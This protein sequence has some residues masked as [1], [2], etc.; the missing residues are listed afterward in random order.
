MILTIIYLLIILFFVILIGWNLFE[1]D[2][3]L[4]KALG[5]IVLIM[6]ILRLVLIK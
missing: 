4:E 2:S 6:L 1:S 5:S 3:I